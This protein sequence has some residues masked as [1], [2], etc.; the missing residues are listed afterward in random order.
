MQPKPKKS[1]ASANANSSKT[2]ANS[3]NAPGRSGAT[4]GA[5]ENGF[6]G[7]LLG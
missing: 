7:Y 4:G 2:G 5:H 6:W 1:K 3:G